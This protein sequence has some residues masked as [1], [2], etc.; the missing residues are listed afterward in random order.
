ML[1]ASAEAQVSAINITG[2]GPC[3]HEGCAEFALRH[4]RF[5]WDHWK[6]VEVKD[7]P[8]RVRRGGR[9]APTPP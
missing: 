7:E 4:E 3:R 2:R 6:F 8:E 9:E 1:G 5:C